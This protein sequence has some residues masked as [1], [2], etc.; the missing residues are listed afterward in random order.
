LNSLSDEV[1]VSHTTLSGWVDILEASF[2]VFRLQ[3]YFANIGKRLVKTPKLYFSET[4]LA[5]NLLG[6]KT[7]EQ[8]ARDPLRG[9]LFE[10]LVVSNIIKQKFNVDA[11]GDVFFFRTS[12]G[13]EIDIIRRTDKG[14]QPI[15]IK[16]S[17]TWSMSLADGLRRRIRMIGDVDSPTVVYGGVTCPQGADGITACNYV[18]FR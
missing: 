10:N 16:A 3:P 17:M 4:A 11:E 8:M 13:E 2:I 9:S 15:E 1:G 14:L 7:K 6:I 5:A 12:N 18:D